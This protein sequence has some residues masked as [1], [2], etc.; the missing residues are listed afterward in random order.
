[1]F[2]R[3]EGFTVK[4]QAEIRTC[5]MWYLLL[6]VIHLF[7]KRHIHSNIS[8]LTIWY[9]HWPGTS[10]S[11]SSFFA[12]LIALGTCPLQKLP[13]IKFWC[14]TMSPLHNSSWMASKRYLQGTSWIYIEENTPSV[15]SAGKTIA[16][17]T[18]YVAWCLWSHASRVK[19]LSEC[20]IVFFSNYDAQRVLSQWVTT[21]SL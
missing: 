18:P 8:S 17:E 16:G 20:S 4:H 7:A 1:M 5:L 21:R 13:K 12:L 14:Q 11:K 15:S 3:G 9:E 2:L 6:N 19:S 10:G